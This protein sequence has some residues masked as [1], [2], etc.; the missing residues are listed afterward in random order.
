[1][2]D[3]RC[4]DVDAGNAPTD[5]PPQQMTACRY[6]A[7]GN[8]TSEVRVRKCGLEYYLCAP[9]RTDDFTA[10]VR[11]RFWIFH[12]NNLLIA[13]LQTLSRLNKSKLS[14]LVNMFTVVLPLVDGGG[15]GAPSF[16]INVR[17]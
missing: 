10:G 9:Q 11:P 17:Q 5:R 1:M 14:G 6:R 16:F 7:S 4:V 12:A 3:I 13:K 8:H 2:T 15:G